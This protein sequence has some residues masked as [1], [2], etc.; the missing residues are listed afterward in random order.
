MLV[1][2]L[3]LKHFVATRIFCSLVDRH[4]FDFS[5]NFL[6]TLHCFCFA[7]THQI[8]DYQV[9]S[10]VQPEN[11]I[12]GDLN[13]P[14]RTS[15]SDELLLAPATPLTRSRYWLMLSLLMEGSVMNSNS[16]LMVI[17]ATPRFRKKSGGQG[18]NGQ[19]SG[20]LE[21]QMNYVF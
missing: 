13:S 7:K 3:E 9:L 2:N 17:T 1:E 11:N 5:N 12:S 20:T 6:Q 15:A 18:I 8:H 4:S 14:A 10:K 19:L 21:K 16:S